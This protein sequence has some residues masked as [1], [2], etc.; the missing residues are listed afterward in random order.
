MN[1]ALWIAQGLVALI[2]ALAGL[3]KLGLSRERLA[4]RIH[5]AGSWSRLRI[6]LLGLAEVAGSIGLLLP[7]ATG[8]APFLTPLAAAC[9][10]VLMVGAVRTHRQLHENVVAPAILGVLCIFIAVGRVAIHP[11]GAER[12]PA[13]AAQELQQ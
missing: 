12:P 8:I 3:M 11:P 13:A 10:G 5:W 7:A 1:T 6:K 4:R 9:L 2:M